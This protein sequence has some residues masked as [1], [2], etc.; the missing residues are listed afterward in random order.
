MNSKI[1]VVIF[2]GAFLISQDSLKISN[3]KEVWKLN[4]IPA[5]TGFVP[6][7]QLENDKPFKAIAIFALRHYWYNEFLIAK[8][9]NDISD[10]NRSFWWMFF[11][12]F[13]GL[14]DAYVDSHLDQLP[15]VDEENNLNNS[16]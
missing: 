14:I 12:Y 13:Y 7:G 6:L 3:D 1:V 9:I 4:L 8:E 5:V 10:R 15:E 2:L 11:L 16:E